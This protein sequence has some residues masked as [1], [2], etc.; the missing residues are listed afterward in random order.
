M[1]ARAFGFDLQM[2]PVEENVAAEH[3]SNDREQQKCQPD[4]AMQRP[5]RCAMP[6]VAGAAAYCAGAKLMLGGV[7]RENPS[8]EGDMPPV[9]PVR[10]G[11]WLLSMFAT[12][13]VFGPG[14]MTR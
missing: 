2:V 4:F 11:R 6:R 13:R 7:L 8:P 3:G 1:A 5:H 12:S 10:P 9:G 14:M